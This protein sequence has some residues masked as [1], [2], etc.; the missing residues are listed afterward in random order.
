VKLLRYGRPVHTVFDLL[1]SKEDDMTYSLGYVLSRSP[2]FAEILIKEIAGVTVS[3]VERAVIAL[4]TI[5]AAA[6]GRT[7][8]EARI[9]G[10]FFAVLEAKRGSNLPSQ[11]QLAQYIPRIKKAGVPVARLVVVTNAP[12]KFAEQALPKQLDGVDVLHLAWRQLYHLSRQAHGQESNR[13]KHLLD[14][15]SGYLQGILGMEASRSNMVYVLSL[16]N[17]G[18]WGLNFKQVVNERRRYFDPVDRHRRGAPN[19]LAFRYDGRLQ[20]IHHV[21]QTEIFTE[22]SKVLEGAKSPPISPCYLFHLGPAI[23]PPHVVKN[24]PKIHRSM[25][26]WCAIDTLLTS[27]TI[28]DAMAETKKRLGAAAPPEETGEPGEGDE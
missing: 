6:E 3:N 4:Q 12:Q 17:G 24:G 10:E 1:G 18:T 20:S 25:R 23:R 19:Y 5:G 22:P 2:R 16:S 28:T 11:G 27:P 7:D 21:E 26:V 13:N 15:F 8:V 14:E 9:D